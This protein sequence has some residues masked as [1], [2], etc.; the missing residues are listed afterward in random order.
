MSSGIQERSM[1][2]EYVYSGVQ[3]LRLSLTSVQAEPVGRVVRVTYSTREQKQ[4]IEA[5]MTSLP[6]LRERDCM[7]E[8]LTFRIPTLVA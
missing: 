4:Q 3:R 7:V 2:I 8:S 5:A 1:L 6:K